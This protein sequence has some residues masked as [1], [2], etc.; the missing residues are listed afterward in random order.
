M[1]GA[2]S[3]KRTS[4]GQCCRIKL[5]TSSGIVTLM[6]RKNSNISTQ[7]KGDLIYGELPDLPDWREAQHIIATGSQDSDYLSL[8]PDY[9]VYEFWSELADLG[10][11]EGG[12]SCELPDFPEMDADFDFLWRIDDDVLK[13]EDAEDFGEELKDLEVEKE[14]KWMDFL[15][16]C[17]FH[18]FDD[19]TIQMIPL[20]LGS[21]QP[22]SEIVKVESN[23]ESSIIPS[24]SMQLFPEHEAEIVSSDDCMMFKKASTSARSHKKTR[25]NPAVARS[26]FGASFKPQKISAETDDLQ[27]TFRYE[28]LECSEVLS[29]SDSEGESVENHRVKPSSRRPKRKM[30]GCINRNHLPEQAVN[31]LKA[32]MDKHMSNP[33]ATKEEKVELVKLSGLTLHQVENWLSNTRYRFKI[34]KARSA[35]K[36]YAEVTSS[37]PVRKTLV[38]RNKKKYFFLW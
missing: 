14:I 31:V 6:C 34:Q 26:H 5:R 25:L 38:A 24:S 37:N 27:K 36:D 21:H 20:P 16:P 1:L 8:P 12:R 32:W 2:A 29:E 4:P 35:T 33:Y 11:D 3:P 22:E 23:N 10:F 18:S 13:F 30:G 9:S 17:S 15:N 28:D 19:Q 7:E